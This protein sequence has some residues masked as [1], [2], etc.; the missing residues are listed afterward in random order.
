MGSV[1]KFRV[2]LLEQDAESGRTPVLR[3]VNGLYQPEDSRSHDQQIASRIG[4]RIPVG[5]DGTSWD[6]YPGAS[7][8]FA[9]FI[10][11]LNAQRS[12]QYIPCFIVATMKVAGSNETRWTS[13]SAGIA[14][15]RHDEVILKGA[16]HVSGQWRCDKSLVHA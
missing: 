13:R 11:D 15:L 9:Y 2:V 4:S 3:S 7:G 10:A 1:N 14:P 16:E 5:M 8:S 12:F 6:E